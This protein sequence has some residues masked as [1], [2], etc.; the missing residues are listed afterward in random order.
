MI[1]SFLIKTICFLFLFPSLDTEREFKKEYFDNGALKGE[2]WVKNN[3]KDGYWVYFFTEGGKQKKG[4]YTKGKKQGYWYFYGRKNELLKEGHFN[5]GW[6][7]GWWTFYENETQLKVTYNKNKRDGFG[8]IYSNK[9]LIKAIKF[10]NNK[11]VGE[12]LSLKVLEET[13]PKC[14]FK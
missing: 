1:A 5:D 13:I 11:K 8:L 12:W 3:L 4:H 10:E 6:M 2:G 7:H 9:R 14:S